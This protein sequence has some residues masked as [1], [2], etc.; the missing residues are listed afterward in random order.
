MRRGEGRRKI[1]HL[2]IRVVNITTGFVLTY[3]IVSDS[4]IFHYKRISCG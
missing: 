1:A 2:H 3:M 4:V